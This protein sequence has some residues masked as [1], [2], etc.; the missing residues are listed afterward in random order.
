MIP[1]KTPVDIIKGQFSAIADAYN[2]NTLK[3][4]GVIQLL[5]RHENSTIE[6][7][8]SADGKSI[9]LDFKVHPNPTCTLSATLYDWLELSSDRLHPVWGVISGRLKF[10]GRTSVFGELIIKSLLHSLSKPVPDD[11][12]PVSDKKVHDK[13]HASEIVIVNG[14]PRGQNGFTYHY[15]SKL[16]DGINKTDSKIKV[17]NICDHSIAPCSGCFSCWE[18]PESG[19]IHHDDVN[20]LYNIVDSSDIVVYAF[21]I[22]SNGVPGILK[23]FID[24]GLYRYYPHMIKTRTA[25]RH[26]KR[27]RKKQSM[28]VFSVCGFSE[29]CHFNAV[30]SFFHQV[31]HNSD[32]PITNTIYRSAG[33]YLWGSP[34]RYKLHTTVTDTLIKAGIEL[35]QKGIIS[36]KLIRQIEKNVDQ[37]E[38][39][40]LSN[41]YWDDIIEKNSVV[42][43][44]IESVRS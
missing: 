15:L 25:T 34:F 32:T 13:K 42:S 17:L 9:D 12:P 38:F 20:T 39:N 22:H 19:C 7:C 23:K 10:K 31:S 3:K 16:I 18:H 14:S 41:K 1:E 35:G 11:T 29:T 28:V 24:R 40:L 4:E 5:L 44:E 6:C 21:P 27:F 36:S 26:P 30:D 2:N 37:K 43:E 33:M 8:F